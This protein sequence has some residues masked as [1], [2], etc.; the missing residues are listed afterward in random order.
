[1]QTSEKTYE[2]R[3]LEAFIAKPQV[4]EWYKKSF[5]KFNVNGV[6]AVAW[7]WSWWGF[8]TGFLYLLYR[9]AYLPALGVFLLSI[10]VGMLPYIGTLFL[11]ILTGGYSTYFIYKE[12]KSKRQSIERSIEDE[13]TRIETMKKIGGYNQWVVWV[14]II[15]TAI[16]FAAIY[17][18]AINMPPL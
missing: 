14:Y 11:M 17:N 7:N 2:D 12:Y 1:M 8:F 4:V 15:F 3:M 6:D 13:E 16:I 9:K 5:E 18:I 10:I